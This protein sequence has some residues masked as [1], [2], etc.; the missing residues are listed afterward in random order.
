M[1]LPSVVNLNLHIN[2]LV[3]VF[4]LMIKRNLVLTHGYN[5]AKEV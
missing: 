4:S 3:R 1:N 5:D 2:L